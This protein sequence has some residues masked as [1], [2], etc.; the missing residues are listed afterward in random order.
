MKKRYGNLE[1]NKMGTNKPRH[2]HPGKLLKKQQANRKMDSKNKPKKSKKS[3][4]SKRVFPPPETVVQGPFTFHKNVVYVKSCVAYESTFHNKTFEDYENIDSWTAYFSSDESKP[5]AIH[6]RYNDSNKP[7]ISF[8]APAIRSDYYGDFYNFLMATNGCVSFEIIFVGNKPPLNPMPNNFKYIY[9][10]ESPSKCLEIAARKAVGE[11]LI[12]VSDDCIF[13]PQFLCSLWSWQK[14]NNLSEC[15]L[16]WR[17]VENGVID[18]TLLK[19]N[20]D[21]K[22]NMF[23]GTGGMF[24]REIW[25][26]LGGID[27]RFVFPYNAVVDMQMRFYEY[28]FYPYSMNICFTI[29]RGIEEK[30]TDKLCHRSETLTDFELL[31]ILWIKDN[32]ISTKRLDS[33][34][35]YLDI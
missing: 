13:S 26:K 28:G 14:R 7:Y 34:I 31:K 3:K 33:V 8:I 18:D 24:N 12:P 30:R 29:N 10:E 11:Y 20:A 27:S 21:V 25:Y 6:T 4:K 5:Y 1:E 16:T 19:F 2:I 15:L 9:S 23:L 35:S 17:H 32:N 22:K